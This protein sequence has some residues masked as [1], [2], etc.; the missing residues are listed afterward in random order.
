MLTR[1]RSA[2]LALL[3][4]HGLEQGMDS[5]LHFHMDAYTEDLVRGG[6]GREEAM[7]RAR[8]EFGSMERTKQECR[9]S[10]GL[11]WPDEFVRNTRYAIRTLRNSPGFALA[12]ILTL[13]LCIGANTA[14]F[15]VID[16]VLLRPLP[17]P[18]PDRLM[19]LVL[20]VRS[21]SS[22]GI[23]SSQNGFTWEMMRDHAHSADFAVMGPSFIGLN[24]AAQGKAR[25]V[26]QHRVSSGYFQVLGTP[27]AIG[28]E[29]T[30]DEDR[31]GGP[32][33]VILSHSLWQDLFHSDPSVI[34]TTVLLRGEPHAIVGIMPEHYRAIVPTDLWTALRPSTKGEGSGE[35]YMLIAR[36]H[37]GVTPR[38]ASSEVEALGARVLERSPMP[39]DTVARFTL[40]SLQTGLTGEVRARLYF[41]WAAV[42][43]V[44]L[45]GCLN[46]AGL[47]LVRAGNRTRE[48]AT[49]VALGGGHGAVL[50]QLLTESL[51]VSAFGGV[52]G[53]ALGYLGIQGIKIFAADALGVLQEL[54]LD[55]RVLLMTAA[56]SL[57]TSV[58]FGLLPAL[59]AARLDVRSG[60]TE[61]G[62]RGIAGSTSPWPRRTLVF[63]EVA[64]GMM[65]LAAAG[66]MLRTFLHLRHLSSGADGNN[67]ITATLSLQDARYNTAD[68]VN[69]LL[70]ETLDR[71]RAIPGVESAGVGLGIPYDRWLNMQFWKREEIGTG[72][73]SHGTTM[74][75]VTPGYFRSLRVPLRAGRDFG[76]RDS[77]N[78]APVAIVSTAF[79][80]RFLKTTDVVGKTLLV[81]GEKIPREIVGV[82]G[83]LQQRPGWDSNPPMEIVPALYVP[84][85]QVSDSFIQLVHTW[86]APKWVVRSTASKDNVVAGIRG[87][88]ESVD[89]L[90]PFASFRGLDDWRDRTLLSQ[91]MQSWLLGALAALALALAA[92]GVYG[93]IAS[94]VA[95][96]KREM[97][98][99]L[100]LGA[101]VRRVI[102]KAALPGLALAIAGVVSGCLAAV[103]VIGALRKAV[104]GLSTLDPWTFV[105]VGGVLLAVAA[106]ASFLPALEIT[107]LNPASTLRDE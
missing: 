100:A 77:A 31:E 58:L 51:V 49:R 11:T 45:I 66:L 26:E 74:N 6:M 71:I 105:A 76:E 25:Y 95:Q 99:R 39:K 69:R 15:S 41:L 67:V 34:G 3:G 107:R 102:L 59:R 36:L 16:A 4:R 33:A 82:V 61:G 2:I 50:R 52:A 1:L 5:E 29:F 55:W 21:R 9:E 79:V 96:R 8:L 28:R 40:L 18:E 54:R 20:E 101:P 60:L 17:Y 64:L 92:V 72:V 48:I 24:L 70:T 27:P 87:A 42:G 12:S 89:P 98:I 103:W 83:D 84:A 23:E 68:R 73:R 86:F 93:L 7:R 43:V 97:G 10:R 75:Y 22:S 85:M 57:L 81:R 13:A 90:L 80:N 19:Q 38:Q 78:A 56:V 44:L 46:I 30:K 35:N 91:R 37:S 94:T 63:G 32:P 62:A 53:A 104:Y 106:A 47:L 88:V 65:L 14:I